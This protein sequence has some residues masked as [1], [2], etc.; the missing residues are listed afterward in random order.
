[1]NAVFRLGCVLAFIAPAFGAAASADV[2]NV[3]AEILRLDSARIAAILKGDLKTL[4]GLFSDDMVYIHS[5][6]KI[7]TKK[8]YLAMLAGGNLNYVT[9]RYDPAPRVAVAGRDT[10]IVTG[11]ATIETKNKAGQLTQRVLTTTTVYV[12]SGTEW[13]VISYQGTPVQP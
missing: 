1:M 2:R 4:E 9:L 3:E 7:D 10:A 6:G 12:R 11:K 5:G 13:Q 8:G